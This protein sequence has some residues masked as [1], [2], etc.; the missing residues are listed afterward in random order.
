MNSCDAADGDTI[1]TTYDKLIADNTGAA[2][3]TPKAN[4]AAGS[5]VVKHTPFLCKVETK[6]RRELASHSMGTY[7]VAVAG[8][9]GSKTSLHPMTK[10]HQIDYIAVVDA[11]ADSRRQLEGREL[12]AHKKTLLY[13]KGWQ[14]DGVAGTNA[15]FDFDLLVAAK[16]TH[17]KVVEHC[18]LHGL[19]WGAKVAVKDILP[20]PANQG[21]PNRRLDGRDL[22]S[23]T[24]KFAKI[25]NGEDPC[26]EPEPEPKTPSP[27]ASDAS[28][29]SLALAVTTAAAATFL[30]LV[31]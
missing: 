7:R 8:S 9:E 11:S 27:A 10:D 25:A 19:W 31:Y 23:H 13:M 20:C 5:A 21:S 6:T 16:V 14:N 18:N 12:A 24:G 22:A 17:L 1:V 28:G 2:G 29:F 15:G 30:G 4:N 26:P 3:S